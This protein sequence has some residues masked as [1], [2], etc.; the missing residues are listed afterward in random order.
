LFGDTNYFNDD[1]WEF[2][3]AL[4]KINVDWDDTHDINETIEEVIKKLKEQKSIHYSKEK[5]KTI[6]DYIIHADE[7]ALS[8]STRRRNGA[9]AAATR[10]RATSRNNNYNNRFH[11]N[12]H[13]NNNNNNSNGVSRKYKKYPKSNVRINNNNNNFTRRKP[14]G[15]Q[16]GKRR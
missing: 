7:P 11:Y 6:L 14:H 8:S 5:A 10:G 13:E 2:L 1:D 4:F 12:N 3:K 16:S 15:K 9:S